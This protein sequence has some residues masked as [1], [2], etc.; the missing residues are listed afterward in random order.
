MID[1]LKFLVFFSTQ[2]FL[3][4][5]FNQGTCRGQFI[6]FFSKLTWKTNIIYANIWSCA[7][8]GHPLVS[9]TGRGLLMMYIFV[10]P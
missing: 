3:E 8:S 6:E 10:N 4:K 5:N 7:G 2:D 9:A 1:S